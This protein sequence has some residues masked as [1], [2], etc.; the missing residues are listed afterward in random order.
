[1]GWNAKRL[2]KR[3]GQATPAADPKAAVKPASTSDDPG[4]SYNK[5][6]G[7]YVCN[8]CGKQLQTEQGMLNHIA[9]KHTDEE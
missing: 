6:E 9:D 7:A 5:R 1:M 8:Y 2:A 4:Y 3:M